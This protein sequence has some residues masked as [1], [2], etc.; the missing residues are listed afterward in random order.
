MGDER[1]R[2]SGR[3]RLSGEDKALWRQVTKS[4]TPLAGRPEEPPEPPPA[5]PAVEEPP[6]ARPTAGRA[7]PP[8]ATP[9]AAPAKPPRPPLVPVDRR[10]LQKVGRGLVEIDGRIDLH[11]LTQEAARGRLVAFLAA[12]QASGHRIVLVITGKG[13][14]DDRADPLAPGRG[15]LRR[16]VPA[17]LA[18][19]ALRA[20]V[21]GFSEARRQH[22]G[23]G[24]LYVRLRRPGRGS[25][26]R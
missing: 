2:R 7:S 8:A 20:V 11:G 18:S 12:A 4:I 14:A 26:E 23:A 25:G 15:V 19:P 16:M 6:P 17:W 1:R 24:A 3:G 9:A 21:V 13:A 22:G 10:T 5:A